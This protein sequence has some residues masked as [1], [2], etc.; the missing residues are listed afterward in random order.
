MQVREIDGEEEQNERKR[1]EKKQIGKREKI[2]IIAERERADKLAK[3]GKEEN[4]LMEW[5]R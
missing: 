4:K 1:E 5:L 3:G 2:I